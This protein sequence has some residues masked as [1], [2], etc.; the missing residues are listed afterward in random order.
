MHNP[1]DVLFSAQAIDGYTQPEAVLE[2]FP[3]LCYYRMLGFQHEQC[4]PDM[5]FHYLHYYFW[6]DQQDVSEAL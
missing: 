5:L 1:I 2:Y 3:L 4:E 6:N